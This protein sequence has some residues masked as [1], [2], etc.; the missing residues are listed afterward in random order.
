MTNN[1]KYVFVDHN[2]MVGDAD[3]SI[4]GFAIMERSAWE[5]D[6][7]KYIN[8][9]TDNFEVDDPEKDEIDIEVYSSPIQVRLSNYRVKPCTDEELKTFC[10]FFGESYSYQKEKGIM[11]SQGKFREPSYWIQHM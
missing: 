7:Q 1:S 8:H 2:F 11:C 9:V 10:N 4:E 6:A 5:A 3:D